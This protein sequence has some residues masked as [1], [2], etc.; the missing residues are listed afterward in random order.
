[1]RLLL[2]E[3]E[4]NLAGAL[5]GILKKEGYDTDVSFDGSNGLDNALSGIYDVIILDRMLP[6]MNGIDVLKE[7]RRAGLS[8]PVI[9]LTAIDG[10]GERI[11]GLD[12]GADD[13]LA[14]PFSTG[15]LL[16]RIRSV[17]RRNTKE[18]RE[19][20]DISAG[21]IRFDPGLLMVYCGGKE[22]KLTFKEGRLLELLLLNKGDCIPK[23]RIFDKVWGFNTD[24]EISIVE[25]YIH[26]L[27]KKLP[28]VDCGIVIET[29]RGIG[30]RLMETD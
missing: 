5:S 4:K 26:H 8:T 18:M 24:S 17:L 14:K 20:K 30:Y 15:E 6:S 27:R 28:E 9:L 1:M 29:I 3:D 21:G 22:I 11:T 16:A 7:I 10:A 12:A 23:D 19:G 25:I 2:V 13:Y